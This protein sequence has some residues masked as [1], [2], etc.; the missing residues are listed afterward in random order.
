[1]ADRALYLDPLSASVPCGFLAPSGMDKVREF[2]TNNTTCDIVVYSLIFKASNIIYNPISHENYLSF[3]KYSNVCFF[4]FVDESTV[5]NGYSLE[6]VSI[7]QH[8]HNDKKTKFK[9]NS[10]IYGGHA[11]Q[12]IMLDKLPYPSFTHSMKAI[13]LLGWRL[14]PK[15]KMFVWF[16]PKYVLKRK[17]LK[18]VNEMIDSMVG[19]GSNTSISTSTSTSS[20]SDYSL[21]GFV[22]RSETSI[23]IAENF[24]HEV[25]AG[26]QGAHDRMIY[27]HMNFKPNPDLAAELQQLK[28]QKAIYA[29][30][31]LF[32]RTRGNNQ[33]VVDTAVMFYRNNDITRRY[34]CAWANEV[35]MFSRRDQLSE[36]A[37]RE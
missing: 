33:L 18:F 22:N 12:I 3:K 31:K 24:F 25:E 34:F 6:P 20:H 14:F 7:G 21:S 32:D 35:S 26:F 16:D 11:W 9:L 2:F 15:A 17:L 23:A 37:V 8:N 13:K 28:H 36:Y 29:K 5:L 27:Q 4:L 1:M 19:G 30:E 10:E